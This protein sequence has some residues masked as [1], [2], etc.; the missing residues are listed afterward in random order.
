[1]VRLYYFYIELEILHLDTEF[2]IVHLKFKN[3]KDFLSTLPYL[4]L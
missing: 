1:M 4:Y 3:N 2:H